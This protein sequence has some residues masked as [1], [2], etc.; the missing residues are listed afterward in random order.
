MIMKGPLESYPEVEIYQDN[1]P[2]RDISSMEV[3]EGREALLHD[4]RS[5]LLL[6][7]LPL[8]NEVEQLST[9]AV[10]KNSMISGY[11]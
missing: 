5:L 6:Q 3:L 2:V 7:V 1:L 8:N 4:Q 11:K 9:L 10:S